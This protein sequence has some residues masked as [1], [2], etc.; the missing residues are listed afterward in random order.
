MPASSVSHSIIDQLPSNVAPATPA[1]TDI[2]H[3]PGFVGRSVRT[4][5]DPTI[6]PVRSPDIEESS[7]SNIVQ[8]PVTTDPSWKIVTVTVLFPV[9]TLLNHPV[10]VPANDPPANDP[11]VD[12][13]VGGTRPPSHAMTDTA[14]STTPSRRSALPLTSPV[15][16]RPME[17]TRCRNEHCASRILTPA[18]VDSDNAR[19]AWA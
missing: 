16:Q 14:S 18:A 7:K 11:P 15:P 5:V 2:E 19:I 4:A 3:A 17:P 9:V 1:A 6:P 10:H 8:N 13:A 12:G